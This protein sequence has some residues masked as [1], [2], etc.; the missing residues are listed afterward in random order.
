RVPYAILLCAVRLFWQ[1]WEHGGAALVLRLWNRENTNIGPMRECAR[2]WQIARPRTISAIRGLPSLRLGLKWRELQRAP[3][4]ARARRSGVECRRV[5]RYGQ[6]EH[7]RKQSWF[8]FLR[9]KFYHSSGEPTPTMP[10]SC[11]A[12]MV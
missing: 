7:E 4:T 8:S 10:V 2:E 9:P 3:S 12:R 5:L 11:G 6:R 1:W